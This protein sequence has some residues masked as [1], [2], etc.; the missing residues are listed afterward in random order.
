M[1][2][3][4]VLDANVI[5]GL[6]YEEDAKQADACALVERIGAAGREVD[7]VDFLVLEAVSVLGRRAD[8]RKTTPPD[9]AE[10]M[11]VVGSWHL[12]GASA[13]QQA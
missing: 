10:C 13:M 11:R 3:L 9:F 4:V 12:L 2:D 6:L 1:A 8:Q 5:V 7:L